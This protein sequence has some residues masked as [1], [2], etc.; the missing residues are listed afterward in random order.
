MWLAVG[1][2]RARQG[3]GH[4]RVGAR[5]QSRRGADP[6]KRARRCAGW[7]WRPGWAILVVA[8]GRLVRAGAAA[9]SRVRALRVPRGV[10]R[11]HDLGFVPARAA[12]VVRARGVRGR[13]A[14][15]VAGHA[16]APAALASRSRIA[17]AFVLFAALFFTLSHSKLVTYLLPAFPALAWWAAECW[18]RRRPAAAAAAR[19]RP[20]CWPR[21]CWWAARRGSRAMRRDAVR[22]GAGGRNHPRRRRDSAC[23]KIAIVRVPTTCSGR[24]SGVVSGDGHELTS[25]YVV[26][27]RDH[28]CAS[29][30]CGGSCDSLAAAP[31]ADWRVVPAARA[32]A[33]RATLG[34]PVFLDRRFAAFRAPTS[35]P[36]APHVSR[37]VL[38]GAYAD[39]RHRRPRRAG[40]RA[41]RA[42]R[43]RAP[44]GARAAAPRTVRRSDLGRRRVRARHRAAR[45]RGARTSRRA[46]S[47]ARPATS[48]ASPTAR[49]TT[50]PRCS[51]ALRARGHDVPAGPDTAVL[52]HLLEERGDGFPGRARR[53]VRRRDVG[54]RHAHADAGARPRRR[55]AAVRRA[56]ARPLRVRLRAAARCS[57][58]PWV[59]RDPSPAAIA[60][61]LVHGYFAGADS[62]FAGMRQ[63]P[64]AHTLVVREGR[65]TL[66]RYWRPWDALLAG[67]PERDAS[68]NRPRRA[69]E[70]LRDAVASRVPGEV[71]FGVFLSGG[72]DSGLVATLAARHLRPRASPR[73]ACAS[74]TGLRRIGLRPPRGA[75]SIGA[76]HHELVMT[77]ARG[78]GG[79][80]ALGRG[81]GPAA[82][83]PE[84]AADVGAGAAR[85]RSTC[86]W[87]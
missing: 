38:N 1:A 31:R 51:P 64:P 26:R 47:R 7:R 12:A 15:V 85:R 16:V 68:P 72:V 74:S 77:A 35:T 34:P 23:T 13:R 54:P 50:T 3:T 10:A 70:A 41:P 55:E 32:A 48:S 84:R 45:D 21:R 30:A 82:R 14:A 28:A 24:V 63:L 36:L 29:A 43:A 53:H 42:P 11:A 71:P 75:Q 58:L 79:V 69:R 49:S 17:L 19:W 59:S 86:R 87:C 62:A 73:S 80:P 76:E 37:G 6:A 56:R 60:R 61:Y 46:C 66:R 52:P 57:T 9:P 4:A 83:R 8:R 78:R 22:R 44:H 65:E 67:T 40:P 2:R 5:R 39:V 25:N 18:G 81:H 20:C 33:L 27:Y